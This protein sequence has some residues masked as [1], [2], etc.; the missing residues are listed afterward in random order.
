MR[1]LTNEIGCYVL[2]DLDAVPMY[3]GQSTNGIR[4]RVNRHLTSARSDIIANRQ[5]DVA[6]RKLDQAEKEKLLLMEKL[7][8]LGIDPEQLK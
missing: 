6:N 4:S 1:E 3:V 5:I 2:C 7:R 8:S